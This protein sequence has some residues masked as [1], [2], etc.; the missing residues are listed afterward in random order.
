M[1]TIGPI[2]VRVKMHLVIKLAAR[3]STVMMLQ[4]RSAVAKFHV[5]DTRQA[6]QVR[7]ETQ[8]SQ[9]KRWHDAPYSLRDRNNIFGFSQLQQRPSLE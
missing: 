7:F 3:N 9:I 8:A 5:Q 6:L 2:I 4:K 1:Q